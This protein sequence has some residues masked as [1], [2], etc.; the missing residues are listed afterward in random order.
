MYTYVNTLYMHTKIWT[1]CIL[2]DR[3]QMGILVLV[4][5]NNFPSDDVF[6]VTIPLCSHHSSSDWQ[7]SSDLAIIC[8]VMTYHFSSDNTMPI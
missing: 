1:A 4:L 2:F 8:R 7:F 5:G 3:P 6:Q